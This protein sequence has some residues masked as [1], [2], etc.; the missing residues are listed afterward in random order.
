MA[1]NSG[2]SA[3]HQLGQIVGNWF[4]EHIALPLLDD[5][6][7]ELDL[8]CDSRFKTRSCRGDKLIWPDADGNEVDYDFVYELEGNA[9]T[10]GIPVAFFETFWRRGSR[11][12][13]DK[14][15][16]DSGKLLGMRDAYATARLLGIV[17]AGDFTNPAKDLVRS[18]GISL[19]YTSKDKIVASWQDHGVG[20]D[21]PD[22]LPEEEK[23]EIVS[24][25][26]QQIEAN[27]AL[28]GQI[29]T[30]VFERI[31]PTEL[32]SFSQRVAGQIGA[33]PQEYRVYIIDRE[34]LRFQTR[35]GIDSFLA[36]SEPEAISDPERLYGYEVVFGDGDSFLRDDLHWDEVQALHSQLDRLVDHMEQL[37]RR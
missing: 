13:K 16:D 30:S 22:K 35:D 9:D 7:G 36:G 1:G 32:R 33:T 37:A 20:I 6:A 12:S 27:P 11:H 28:L 17:A 19:F 31:G 14:A 5:V 24:T 21:Y 23:R 4:E 3:G 18:R 25:A 26:R 34:A 29:A 10:R 8:Y 15:R 2:A